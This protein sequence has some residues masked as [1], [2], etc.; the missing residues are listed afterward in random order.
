MNTIYKYPF[1]ISNPPIIVDLPPLHC[2][3]HVEAQE[4]TPTMWIELDPDHDT[5]RVEF[6]IIGTGGRVPPGAQH[7][8][9]FLQGPF[10]WH[11]YQDVYTKRRI[12]A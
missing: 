7:I 6:L 3:V 8:G 12:P 2:V 4:G 10:V 1:D 9:T 5:D 11:V